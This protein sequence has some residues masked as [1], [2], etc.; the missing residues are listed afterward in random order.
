MRLGNKTFIPLFFIVLCSCNPSPTPTEKLKVQ[1]VENGTLITITPSVLYN[2]VVVENVTFPVLFGLESCIVCQ[3]SKTALINYSSSNHMNTYYLEMDGLSSDEVERIV[4][5]TTYAE[6]EE[7]IYNF[8]KYEGQ[9]PLM[10]IFAAK[11]PFFASYDK[12]ITYLDKCIEVEK[13]N[14]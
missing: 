9:Y 12:F 7:S 6:G 10:Y 8:R 2:M 14:S 1:Y 11:T 3:E 13:P 5:A 4:S